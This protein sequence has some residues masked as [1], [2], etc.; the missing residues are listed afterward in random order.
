M[1]C[2]E[3]ECKRRGVAVACGQEPQGK[4]PFVCPLCGGGAQQRGAVVPCGQEPQERARQGGGAAQKG[5]S[6]LDRACARSARDA[7]LCVCTQC[8]R[9]LVVRVH[10]VPEMLGCACAR[11]ANAEG[12]L[13]YLSFPSRQGLSDAP[14]L[15]QTEIPGEG[16]SLSTEL[17]T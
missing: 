15:S 6:A 4:R 12:S 1:Q 10:A 8:Q 3:L 7:W 13:A 11:G 14:A 17:G 9:C 16:D 2:L 5:G